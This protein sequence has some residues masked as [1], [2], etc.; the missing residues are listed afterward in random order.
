M[1][2]LLAEMVKLL[3][4]KVI[5]WPERYI[6]FRLKLVISALKK[7]DRNDYIPQTTTIIFIFFLKNLIKSCAPP[8][9]PR[10]CFVDSFTRGLLV[11]TTAT[12]CSL[13]SLN[14]LAEKKSKPKKTKELVCHCQIFFQQANTVLSFR[15]IM[16][17]P[18]P[19]KE[20]L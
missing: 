5:F 20:K 18:N 14:S 8:T 7:T 13:Y 16:V 3:A 15:N 9:R 6:P 4:E 17:L 2:H 11:K 10:D 19:I 12:T 1:V